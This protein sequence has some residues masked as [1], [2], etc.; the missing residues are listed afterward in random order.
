M[1]KNEPRHTLSVQVGIEDKRISAKCSCVA[2][3]SGYCHHVVG[4]LFYMSHCKHLGLK[5]L[6]DELACTSLPQMWSVPR[7]KKIANKATQD[8]MVKKPQAGADYAKFD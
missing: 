1:K 4:L 8:I 2:G 6:P 5:S 3:A 7:Q